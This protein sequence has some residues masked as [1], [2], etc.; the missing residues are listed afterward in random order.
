MGFDWQIKK[1]S[2]LTAI[3]L[4]FSGCSNPQPAG[5][6]PAANAPE[7]KVGMVLIGPKEDAGWNQAHYE[8]MQYVLKKIPNLKFDYID[9]VNPSDRPNIKGYQVADNLISK[10]AKLIIFNSEDYKDDALET[11][12]KHPNIIVIH[13]SGDY[14]W[15]EG[16]N[17]KNQPN[18]GN[19]MGK[20]EYGKM[21]SGCA[22]ALETES[23]KIGYLGSLINEETRRL[24]SSTYLGLAE[25]SGKGGWL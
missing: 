24:S 15:K 20:I 21:I 11:A 4:L 3:S 8:G 25:R 7:Y 6:I 12:K 2:V 19:I 18:L 22:A 23:G 13:A 5:K 14:A 16:K 17:F 9:K 1:F 10:G